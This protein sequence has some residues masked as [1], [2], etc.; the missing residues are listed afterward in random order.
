M[1]R[2]VT[3]A[4]NKVPVAG[5]AAA[6]TAAVGFAGF[7]FAN[8]K[9]KNINI[10]TGSVG[11]PE[12]LKALMPLV[13]MNATK[14][15]APAVDW[16]AL[17]KDICDVLD[18]EDYMEE[19]P[20]PLFVRLAW[21]SAGTYDKGDGS[22]GSCGAT[23]RFKPECDWGANAGLKRGHALL[24]PLKK[25]YPGVGNKIENYIKCSNKMWKL[26]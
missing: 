20:G 2:V 17:R 7:Y 13:G 23:M 4:R 8:K 6:G 24:E 16:D 14:C 19:P 10:N 9:S 18:H 12:E 11:L 25:K 21:H 1:F 3:S 22:G 15:E 26:Q 5:A